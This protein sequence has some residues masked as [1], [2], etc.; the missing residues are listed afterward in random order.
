MEIISIADDVVRPRQGQ[1]WYRAPMT[2]SAVRHDIAD[3]SKIIPYDEC[4]ERRGEI[5][6]EMMMAIKSRYSYC[7]PSN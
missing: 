4:R 7:M 6:A 2:T 1:R 5:Y 3:F